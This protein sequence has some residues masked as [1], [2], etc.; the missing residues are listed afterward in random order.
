MVHSYTAEVPCPRC[1][2][3]TFV[4]VL[5]HGPHSFWAACGYCGRP[6]PVG[7]PAGADDLQDA[8]PRA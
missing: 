3:L 7:T 8:Q 5:R 1:G 4:P 2:H 6:V